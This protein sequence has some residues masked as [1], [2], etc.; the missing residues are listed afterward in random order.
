MSNCSSSMNLDDLGTAARR[1]SSSRSPTHHHEM[2]EPN[3][4]E[5]LFDTDTQETFALLHHP[6][7]FRRWLAVSASRRPPRRRPATVSC[8]CPAP[9][10][11]RRITV[12]PP[13][14]VRYSWG[15]TAHRGSAGVD[16]ADRRA[17]SRP[18][19][20][21][22]LH[23]RGARRGARRLVIGRTG[24]STSIGWWP[25]PP[26]DAGLEPWLIDP[27]DKNH[28][29][30]AE[31]TW[32]ICR[33]QLLTLGPDDADRPTPCADFN[34]HELVV[35]LRNSM[36]TIGSAVGAVFDDGAG[37][38]VGRGLRGRCRRIGT[39]RMAGAGPRR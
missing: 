2:T 15:R 4:V 32:A 21:V 7:G 37:T 20:P 16:D 8:E 35:H 26:G 10:R 38:D 30:V 25:P 13:E 5:R 9:R 11:R 18:A 3:L 33:Q 22:P 14:R 31:A 36:V 12:N 6:T 19:D 1:S 34:A 29:T 39:R 24:P 27:E 23:P 28:L 17:S